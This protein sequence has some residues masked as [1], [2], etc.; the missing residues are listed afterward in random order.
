M[1]K[2]IIYVTLLLLFV[3]AGSAYSQSDKWSSI[4]YSYSKGPVSP[5]YQYNFKINLDNN[6]NGK[7]IYTKAGNT[8]EYDFMAGK[9][10]MRKLNKA[11]KKSKIFS[12]DSGDMSASSN[13]VGGPQESMSVTMWQSPLLDAPPRVIQVPEQLNERYSANVKKVYEIIEDLVPQDIW[14]TATQ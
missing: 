9:K 1:K 8:K 5:E 14:Y 10:G 2:R 7:L 11:L 6:G 13:R 3:A 4:S 12:V